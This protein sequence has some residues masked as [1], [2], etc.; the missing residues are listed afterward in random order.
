MRSS[1]DNLAELGKEIMEGIKLVKFNVFD[2]FIITLR[3]KSRNAQA[4]N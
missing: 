4:E 3:P 1:R 2:V